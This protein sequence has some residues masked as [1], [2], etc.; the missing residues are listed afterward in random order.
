MVKVIVAR[1]KVDVKEVTGQFIDESH[2]DEIIDEDCDFYAPTPYGEDP[3]DES[4]LI[5][6]FRKNAFT[7]KE[8]VEAYLGLVDAAQPQTNRGLAAG[9]RGETTGARDFVKAV[10]F[11]ILRYFMTDKTSTLY[12]DDT[13]DAQHIEHIRATHA[14]GQV[15]DETRGVVWR[16]GAVEE[17]G[18]EYGNWFD[19]W[20]A[21]MCTLS[22]EVQLERTKDIY[23]KFISD[24][25]YAA[26]VNSGVAGFYDRY[27]RF[28][29][30]RVTSYSAAN[31]KWELAFP[32]LKRLNE[33]FRELVPGKYAAQKRAADKLDPRF[34]VP[35]SVFTTIT[36]NKNFR[37]AAHRDAGDLSEGFSNLAALTG[38]EGKAWTGAYLTFPEFRIA[39][40]VRPGDLLLANNH[41]GMH[42]NSAITSPIEESD[43]C[44]LVCY[45]RENML[46]LGSWEYEHIRKD[47]V[48]SRRMNK[49]HADWRAGWNGVSPGMWTS[50]EWYDFCTEKGGEDMLNK[51]HLGANSVG[52]S[53][54]DFF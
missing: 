40:N 31:A 30:G 54:E 49:E 48:E 5:F 52:P 27:P 20:V 39:V 42:G 35:D 44:T 11:D 36:V 10:E 26:A 16:R 15:K 47:F 32:Y 22:K 6:K 17:A 28:P 19:Q 38:P 33:Y 37:T 1:T 8:Y 14:A 21:Q 34:L 4:R 29:Y 46:E 45:F 3:H 13:S 24:T 51:Y 12:E 2:Y 25:S 7:E 18:L 43:R 9:P 23:E 41:E 50:R 53:L